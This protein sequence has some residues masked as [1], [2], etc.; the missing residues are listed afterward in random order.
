MLLDGFQ[1]KKCCIICRH[2]AI[3]DN[4][5]GNFIYSDPYIDFH[6]CRLSWFYSTLWC[7]RFDGNLPAWKCSSSAVKGVH[8]VL[9]L[10]EEYRPTN[11]PIYN[12]IFKCT[13]SMTAKFWCSS[14]LTSLAAYR[15]TLIKGSKS[16]LPYI[17]QIPK[18]KLPSTGCA[19]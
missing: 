15:P 3:S 4:I 1:L 8:F 5:K 18:K 10:I 13:Y 2:D 17:F 6:F 9:W 12:I 7:L 14:L 16:Q 19:G 11:T